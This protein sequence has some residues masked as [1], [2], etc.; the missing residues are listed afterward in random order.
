[1]FK[2]INKSTELDSNVESFTNIKFLNQKKTYIN[3]FYWNK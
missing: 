2:N 1:L 3:R